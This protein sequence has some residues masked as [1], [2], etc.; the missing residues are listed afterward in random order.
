MQVHFSKLVRAE[1]SDSSVRE[2]LEAPVGALVGV[3]RDD[4]EALAA[5]NVTT[6]YDLAT[7][8]VFNL[9]RELTQAAEGDGSAMAAYGFAP[10]DA[11]VSSERV[12]FDELVTSDIS[13]L[14]GV[15]DDF[16]DTVRE[17]T[18]LTTVRDFSLWP[19][20]L[21][22]RTILDH[23]TGGRGDGDADGVPDEL[24]P[25]ARQYAT[26]EVFYSKLFLDRI[27]EPPDTEDVL[28]P[29]EVPGGES[30]RI[31]WTE[32]PARELG[33]RGEDSD[34]E[35]DE[36]GEP[37][38]VDLSDPW[39]IEPIDVLDGTK[40]GS[41]FDRPALGA[42]LTF[43]QTWNPEGLSLGQLLH[44]LSLA[45]GETTK[46]AVIDWSRDTRAS[47]DEAI[48]QRERL[49]ARLTRNRAIE[50]VQHS[51]LTEMQSGSSSTTSSTGT[52]Q[53]GVAGL[54]GLGGVS[55]GVGGTVGGGT[56]VSVSSGRRAVDA[57]MTQT[58]A[59]ST[60]QH[61]SSARTRRASIVR[62]VSQAESE[63]VTTRTVTNYNHMHSLNMHYYEVVQIYRVRVHVDRTK[64]VLFV[65]FERSN[66]D[67]PR[68]IRRHREAL[69]DAADDPYLRRLLR[70]SGGHVR[71]ERTLPREHELESYLSMAKTDLMQRGDEH[72]IGTEDD[73]SATLVAEAH[74][75]EYQDT[76]E[77][78]QEA[79]RNSE[80]GI[81]GTAFDGV[82]SVPPETRLVGWR[83]SSDG[84]APDPSGFRIYRRHAETYEVS[85]VRAA[86]QTHEIAPSLA[87]SDVERI[88]VDVDQSSADDPL[89]IAF[90]VRVED[91]DLPL[92][93]DGVP[94]GGTTTVAS[95]TG[96]PNLAEVAR[97]LN[98]DQLYYNQA[99]WRSLDAQTL[100]TLLS[101]HTY[102][103][104]RVS[105]LV[106][107]TP[108]ATHGNY[109]AFPLAAPLADFAEWWRDW[110]N[111][112]FHPER[113]E[114]DLVPLPSGGVHGEAILGRANAAEKLDPT[115]FWDWQDSPIPITP[116][117][118]KAIETG[119]RK[120]D[121]EHLPGSLD[122]P[123]VSI[124]NPPTVPDP[125][126][127]SAVLNA[128]TAANAFRDMSG[129]DELAKLLTQGIEVTG[130]GASDATDSST[131]IATEGIELTLELLKT[132]GPLIAGAAGG[133]SG[134]SNSTFG[135][136]LRAAE[137]LENGETSLLQDG[138]TDSDDG[139]RGAGS[140]PL[141]GDWSA[142]TVGNDL[143]R[144]LVRSRINPVADSIAAINEEIV[145][146][147]TAAT[148]RAEAEPERV[149]EEWE[150]HPSIH[151][152]FHDG[153]ESY[154]ELRP[155]YQQHGIQ[156]PAQYLDTVIV[157]TTFLGHESP[158]HHDLADALSDA[159][160]TL[161]DDPPAID[162]FWGFVP[163]LT[164]T[165]DLSDHALGQAVDIDS[166][167]NPHIR[168]SHDI[169][170]IGAVTG[171]DLGQPQDA[172]T[173]RTASERFQSDFGDA[174]VQQ[175]RDELATADGQ[176][177][178]ELDQLLASVERR[179]A[180]LDTY[181][182]EGFLNLEQAL[183][184]ALTDAG[185]EWGGQWRREKDF[186]HFTL[187]D[188]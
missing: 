48:D 141:G 30:P 37:I 19:P 40:D 186:M 8:S 115:R 1:Y 133:A 107:P 181:A 9:A 146:T 180:T 127:L 6:V 3:D 177:R 51:V 29:I 183:I 12:T 108:L 102:D 151:H 73:P 148:A 87:L 41:L 91:R 170:V 65:P 60:Q 38:S 166:E 46:V 136:L 7:S 160:S 116:P 161:Q 71:V 72:L 150:A 113:V 112:N 76:V 26:E 34:R 117:D 149:R 145:E 78:E 95:V 63:S 32:T 15:G 184:D 92:R 62:E 156:N 2:I 168:N 179:R 109:V 42:L 4:E 178:A 83:W 122:A 123:M 90:V 118:I 61:A 54:A 111:E 5:L 174:W 85:D 142:R 68:L 79:R 70:R 114:E 128:V 119:T 97:L 86:D 176:E 31:S 139:G 152:H 154:R 135:M 110:R 163:R 39:Q 172:Q 125:A 88:E 130:A 131:E 24:V 138:G 27:I 21:A 80:V 47:V 14:P 75:L 120:T 94:D 25:V 153:F 126:G 58:I 129:L 165:G 22:A 98:E 45:P 162:R 64:P 53:G 93:F 35:R 36:T 187:E 13:V 43:S 144:R 81:E 132:F 169:R 56:T 44:S 101:Q 175:K 106:D 28:T 167:T 33:E 157:P 147:I 188:G 49:D 11:T 10:A 59:D 100:A 74:E 173:M 99:I 55:T 143:Q 104:R 89:R 84:G 52:G 137:G 17:A 69:L 164:A 16:D 105:E 185:F 158:V 121:E 134:L 124:Q 96:P 77:Q 103:G 57:E 23:L 18:S 82:W 20:F 159:E 171:V 66:F 155:H 140:R 182:Q 67:D 50:E